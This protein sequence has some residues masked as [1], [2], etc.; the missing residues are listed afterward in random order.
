MDKIVAK[1]SPDDL[2]HQL[3][4][5]C[6]ELI[7]AATKLRRVLHGTNPTPVTKTEAYE[8]LIEEIADVNVASDALR[9][10]LGISCD[11]IAEVENAKIERWRRRIES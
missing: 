9:R 1:L 10:K 7:Q 5:E 4:E 8:C 3:V 6:G 2:F 11:E